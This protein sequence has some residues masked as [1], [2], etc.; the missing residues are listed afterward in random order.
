M[1]RAA[2]WMLSAAIAAAS[3]TVGT[4]KA[5]TFLPGDTSVRYAANA[6]GFYVN[7]T[8][9]NLYPGTSYSDVNP[10]STSWVLD[11]GAMASDYAD[12]GIV[13]YFDGSLTLGQLQSVDISTLPGGGNNTTPTVN[14]WLDT[15]G[16]N[17]FFSFT[18]DQFTGLNGDAY[19]GAT[20]PGDI[21]ASTTFG[22]LGG[23]GSYAQYTL[24]QLQSGARAG[25]DGNTKVALWIGIT[26]GDYFDAN[27]SDISRV[28]VGVSA[29]PLPA[30][31]W[32]G[33]ALLGGLGLVTGMKRVRRQ[34]A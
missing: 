32:S 31:A 29:V 14:L 18:G 20:T 2:C 21:N 5:D 33:L 19:F 1:N 25:I 13:L 8:G 11:A 22:F 9:L 6:G 12:A 30:S 27:Y 10:S 15:G 17:H 16:D 4:A 26:N 28:D 7:S 3:W 34:H 23:P 24:A